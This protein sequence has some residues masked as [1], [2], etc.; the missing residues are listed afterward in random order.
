MAIAEAV[1]VDL[2][3]FGELH[4]CVVEPILR[5]INVADAVEQLRNLLVLLAVRRGDDR[6]RPIEQLELA[7]RIAA[8]TR[9][10]AQCHQRADD[11]LAVGPVE[12]LLHAKRRFEPLGRLVLPLQRHQSIA[13]VVQR[14]CLMHFVV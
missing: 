9:Q 12:T 1:N 3:A 2:D 10:V 11:L 5:A 8:E 4:E 14:H 6:T 13:N 7:R